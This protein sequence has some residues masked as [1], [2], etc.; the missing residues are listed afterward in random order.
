MKFNNNINN[1]TIYTLLLSSSHIN[2]KTK[3]ILLLLLLIQI[4]IKPSICDDDFDDDNDAD[5]M[6]ARRNNDGNNN[7][8]HYIPDKLDKRYMDISNSDPTLYMDDTTKLPK[9]SLNSDYIHQFHNHYDDDHIKKNSLRPSTESIE[10]SKIAK[11]TKIVQNHNHPLITGPPTTTSSPPVEI[12]IS[13]KISPIF[14]RF[15]S[16]STPLIVESQQKQENSHYTHYNYHQYPMAIEST[17]NFIKHVHKP[18]YHKIVEPIKPMKLVQVIHPIQEEYMLIHS[19]GGHHYH[20]HHKRSGIMMM[21]PNAFG[22]EVDGDEAYYDQQYQHQFNQ[23]NYNKSNRIK[24]SKQHQNDIDIGRKEK[25]RNESIDK[26][27]VISELVN[28]SK[29]KMIT[30]QKG[31]QQISST[32]IPLIELT[33]ITTTTTKPLVSKS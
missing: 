31:Q 17:T 25:N 12:E 16:Y 19:G 11:I 13:D 8:H 27:N 33:T 26:K 28:Q 5:V 4:D 9:L 21:M 1:S 3:M 20:Y 10:S 23:Q 18:I 6:T 14:M 24:F 22:N 30:Q 7:H 2:I 15:R 32:L 29:T